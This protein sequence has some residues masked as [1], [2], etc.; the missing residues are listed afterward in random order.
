MPNSDTVSLTDQSLIEQS[1]EQSNKAYIEENKICLVQDVL[2]KQEVVN[3]TV[4][5]SSKPLSSGREKKR[6]SNGD[7]GMV[8]SSYV[9][10]NE[11]ELLKWVNDLPIRLF[12]PVSINRNLI[13]T[14][15]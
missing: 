1:S 12:S 11:T 7:S 10:E 5:H 15:L 8:S 2:D 13:Y 14:D 6:K 3:S 9:F 4:Q